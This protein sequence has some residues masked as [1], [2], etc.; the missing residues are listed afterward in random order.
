MSKVRDKDT[1]YFLDLDVKTG[2]I[3][4]MGLGNRFKLDQ[5]L[6][7]PTHHRIFLTKG[8]FNKLEKKQKALEKWS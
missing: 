8:Q 4:Q 6:Y 1:R 7:D 3:I 2:K 5:E